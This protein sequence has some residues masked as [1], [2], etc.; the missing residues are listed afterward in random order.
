MKMLIV[1]SCGLL[2]SLFLSACESGSEAA[3]LTKQNLKLPEY[4]GETE[5]GLKVYRYEIRIANQHSHFIYR[6]GNL[7]TS[8]MNTTIQQDKTS[9]NQV[10]VL[11]ENTKTN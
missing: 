11:V 9:Y 7:P 3:R 10:A 5:D 8:T 6:F 4:I 1:L 2:F